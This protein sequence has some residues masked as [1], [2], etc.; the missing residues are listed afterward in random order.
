MSARRALV[1]LSLVALQSAGA[2]SLVEGQF[3]KGFSQST[4]EVVLNRHRPPDFLILAPAIKVE[5]STQAG[6]DNG[7][8]SRFQSALEGQLLGNDA[9]L[10][11]GQGQPDTIIS[12]AITKLDSRQAAG[13]RTKQV[14]KQVCTKQEWNAKKR[15]YESKPNYQLVSETE[16]YVTVTGD[17][18]VALQVKDR[19]SGS[20]L[21]SY[22][23]TPNYNQEFKAGNTP[24]STSEVEQQLLD[25]A[26]TQVA[27]RLTLTQ[28]PMTVMLAR[29]NDQIDD[30]NRLGQA[31]QWTTMLEQLQM[32][33]PLKD[34]KK[35]AYRQHNLG[36]ATEAIAYGTPNLASSR[37][38]LDTA[39]GFYRQAVIMKPDEKYFL[40]PQARIAESFSG[41]AEI[42][43]QQKA[44]ADADEAAALAPK[45][46][47]SA[48]TSAPK[49]ASPAPPKTPAASGQ[50][51]SSTAFG[52]DDVIELAAAG[53]DQANLL[54]AIKDARRVSFDLS[55]A[56]LKQLLAAK[57]PNPVITA[58][59]ARQTAQDA[60]P[61]KSA[62]PPNLENPK[63]A[64][65]AKP[66]APVKPPGVF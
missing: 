16:S 30:I 15:V 28:E 64:P 10:R 27:R 18:T 38:L 25:T 33:K 4:T 13:S 21:D 32:M 52:N 66:P 24:P 34:V 61:R 63:P 19:R 14:T 45:S 9:R 3:R 41:Y 12:C 54:A 42:E 58:M 39:A 51:S 55:P 44:I 5:A 17:I 36:V 35:E 20:T 2:V 31:G 11:T 60:P 62:P 56:G 7:T 22:T 40:T 49:S 37:K 46:T 59:R 1:V 53:L 65:G 48:S 57:V 6:R 47:S 23:F 26:V 50:S 43:R 29:P 8:A